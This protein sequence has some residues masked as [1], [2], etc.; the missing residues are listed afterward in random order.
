MC[1]YY[2]AFLNEYV[3]SDNSKL[4]RPPAAT[5]LSFS[6]LAPSAADDE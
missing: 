2:V 5:V 6:S 4:K 1:V 3:V